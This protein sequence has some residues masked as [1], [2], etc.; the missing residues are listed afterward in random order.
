[1]GKGSELAMELQQQR[2]AQT[3]SATATQPGASAE[4][5]TVEGLVDRGLMSIRSCKADTSYSSIYNTHWKN[6]VIHKKWD[7][8]WIK[9]P[10]FVDDA[11]NIKDGWLSSL[12]REA[13]LLHHQ[14]QPTT[15]LYR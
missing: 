3:A 9:S 14:C 5:V 8:K 13:E 1:M 7:T 12:S 10:D 4:D 2:G 11:G 15:P 6:F